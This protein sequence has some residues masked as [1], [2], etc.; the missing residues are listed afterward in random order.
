M[1]F[2]E[3][4]LCK[5]RL[6]HSLL[7]F[8]D[9]IKMLYSGIIALFV[10]L[11]VSICLLS[12][13]CPEQFWMCLFGIGFLIFEFINLSIIKTAE[14]FLTE[15]ESG[16]LKPLMKVCQP[17][18]DFIGKKIEDGKESLLESEN[19]SGSQRSEYSNFSDDMSDMTSQSQPKSQP[20]EPQPTLEELGK[21]IEDLELKE[22]D[23]NEIYQNI[24]HRI[25]EVD[26]D[27]KI[28][29]LNVLPNFCFEE[30]GFLKQDN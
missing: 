3:R 22:D 19:P 25:S 1:F 7:I 26:D 30:T 4:E 24:K 2:Y 23:L 8:F 11:F 15:Q 27:K 29:L 9:S 13:I 21:K 10:F 16:K 18:F 12:C 5:Y 17:C 20:Q 28:E 6:S 14:K